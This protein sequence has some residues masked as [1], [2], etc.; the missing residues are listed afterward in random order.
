MVE[1]EVI[2]G[3]RSILMEG[4]RVKQHSILLPGTVVPPGR[5]I[6]SKQM[7]GGNPAHFIRDLTKDE[8]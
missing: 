5:M 2:V 7:W 3:A 8:V 4:S 6:P 1:R